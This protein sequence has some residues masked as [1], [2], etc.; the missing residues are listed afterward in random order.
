M[1]QVRIFENF[2]QNN[3]EKDINK[4]GEKYEIV[5]VSLT[6]NNYY[7][8]CVVYKLRKWENDEEY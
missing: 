7:C 8:A 3:L 4:F 6:V 5:S 1:N 2:N